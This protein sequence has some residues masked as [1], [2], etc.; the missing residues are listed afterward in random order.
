MGPALQ[1]DSAY[2]RH[3]ILWTVILLKRVHT[4]TYSHRATN[5]QVTVYSP[6]PSSMNRSPLVLSWTRAADFMTLQHTLVL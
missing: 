6:H 2:L 1:P 5:N 3:W 4:Q